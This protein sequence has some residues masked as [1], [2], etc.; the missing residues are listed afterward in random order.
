MLL[1]AQ[2]TVFLNV[3]WINPKDRL[4]AK[5][6][7]LLINLNFVVD[8]KICHADS[9]FRTETHIPLAAEIYGCWKLRVAFLP[10]NGSWVKGVVS[11]KIMPPCQG[12]LAS[13]DH[14]ILVFKVSALLPQFRT[15]L[16][17]HSRS[18]CPY[19]WAEDSVATEPLFSF[20]P[21]QFCFFHFLRGVIFR[22]TPQ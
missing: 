10:G 13:K 19:K 16:N 18:R 12:Q 15:T 9:S 3:G 21:A 20:P 5:A 7:C 14:F 17:G 6:Q 1:I 11:L 4:S 2:Y 22:C 8:T